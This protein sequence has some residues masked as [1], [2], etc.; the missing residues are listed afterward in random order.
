MKASPS[1]LLVLTGLFFG[2][3]FA[4]IEF[5][6]FMTSAEGPRFIVKG[7]KEER[8][9]GFLPL[10]GTHLGFKL[11]AHDPQRGIL[12]VER[13]GERFDLPLKKDRVAHSEKAEETTEDLPKHKVGSVTIKSSGNLTIPEKIVK[14]AM[15]IR[16]GGTFDAASLERDI[17]SIYGTGQIKFVEIKTEKGASD[18]YNLVVIVTPKT[19]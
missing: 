9:S 8:P 2:V 13:N 18:T 14:D 5:V 3:S 15:E 17:R 7:S 10:G 4:Q 1:V 11:V 16:S 6:G 19:P 12:S